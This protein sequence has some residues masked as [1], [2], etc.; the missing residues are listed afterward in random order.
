MKLLAIKHSA[1]GR[2]KNDVDEHRFKEEINKVLA[3]EGGSSAVSYLLTRLRRTSWR[4]IA[5]NLSHFEI[6]LEDLGYK[7]TSV[8]GRTRK[9]YDPAKVPAPVSKPG[10]EDPFAK[11]AWGLAF[12]ENGRVYFYDKKSGRFGRAMPDFISSIAFYSSQNTAQREL[13][14]FLEKRGRYTQEG[15][16]LTPFKIEAGESFFSAF[17]RI[18]HELLKK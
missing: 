3:E 15:N 6:L 11:E 5:S 10:P 18:E 14:K 7:I 1:S 2:F 8:D 4:N 13:N 16:K 17:K 12:L 9:V